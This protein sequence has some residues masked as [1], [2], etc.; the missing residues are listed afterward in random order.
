VPKHQ[1]QP[2]PAPRRRASARSIHL[3][4]TLRVQD[5]R[6]SASRAASVLGAHAPGWPG[7]ARTARAGRRARA[8]AR[9]ATR[10]CPRRWRRSRSRRSACC[11]HC[12]WTR[13]PRPPRTA[14]A[15]G[16]RRRPRRARR[17]PPPPRRGL[18]GRAPRRRLCRGRSPRRRRLR[19]RRRPARRRRRCLAAPARAPPRRGRQ[20]RG[21]RRR[22]RPPARAGAS[23]RRSAEDRTQGN[24]TARLVRMHSPG[25]RSRQLPRQVRGRPQRRN[26]SRAHLLRGRGLACAAWAAGPEISGTAGKSTR[27]PGAPLGRAP[28]QAACPGPPYSA[29]RRPRA[30]CSMLQR[31][32]ARPVAHCRPRAQAS[33]HLPRARLPLRR[34][35]ARPRRPRGRPCAL[36]AAPAPARALPGSR[37]WRLRWVRATQ[38][39]SQAAGSAATQTARRPPNL[40]R[41]WRCIRSQIRCKTTA[42]AKPR[43]WQS[44]HQRARVWGWAPQSPPGWWVRWMVSLLSAKHITQRHALSGAGG[45]V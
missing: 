10:R 4:S 45:P 38:T 3:L 6:W 17:P 16:R 19:R 27:A 11:P 31:V 2:A 29:L 12:R 32:R 25:R 43:A 44:R 13:W 26:S 8:R 20:L 14:S 35:P 23:Q 28:A 33:P 9:P 30:R 40:A 15:C 24:P 39:R 18:R 41:G 34:S 5:A 37:V 7:R 1:C 36:A 22:S 21:R 42:R